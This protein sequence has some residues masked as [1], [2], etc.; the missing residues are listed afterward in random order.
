MIL[1][2][3][4]S[5][6]GFISLSGSPLIKIKAAAVSLKGL[7]TVLF[8]SVSKTACLGSIPTP[9]R[10][11]VGFCEGSYDRRPTVA[12]VIFERSRKILRS[13]IPSSFRLSN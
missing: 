7:K 6:T 9:P 12:S 2:L 10:T 11:R 3:G 5:V 4:L 8:E 13:N 1:S